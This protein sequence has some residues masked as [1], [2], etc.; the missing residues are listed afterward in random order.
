M[1][2]QRITFQ[3]RYPNV[4]LIWIIPLLILLILRGVQGVLSNRTTTTAVQ[5]D[6]SIEPPSNPQSFP[7]NQW[8]WVSPAGYLFSGWNT[9]IYCKFEVREPGGALVSKKDHP[10]ICPSW[11]E[12]LKLLR[13]AQGESYASEETATADNFQAFEDFI[14]FLTG[15]TNLPP[16]PAFP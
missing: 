13:D 1:Q 3:K 8:K 16:P 6:L 12:I 2:A 15:K 14:E 7:P 5:T 11:S 9:A 4:H 10:A